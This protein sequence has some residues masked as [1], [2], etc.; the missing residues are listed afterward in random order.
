MIDTAPTL[1]QVQTFTPTRLDFSTPSPFRI[2]TQI[3]SGITAAS[4]G[5]I[6]VALGSSLTLNG[7]TVPQCSLRLQSSY[8]RPIITPCT[9]T[10]GTFTLT[11]LVDVTSGRYLITIGSLQ[12]GLA[13]DGVTF[14]SNTNRVSTKVTVYSG[15]ATAIDM[16]YLTMIASNIIFLII[17]S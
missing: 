4:S 13:T 1:F 7:L 15:S 12:S 10:S 16:D 9:Y 2:I 14:P 5:Y 8:G 11:P 3:P 17:C 6:Q